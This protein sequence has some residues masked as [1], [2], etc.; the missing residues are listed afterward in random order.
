M[1]NR[2]L[3]WRHNARIRSFNSRGTGIIDTGA[4]AICMDRRIARRLGLTSI[5]RKP[6]EMADGASTEA[7][8]YMVQMSIPDLDYSEWTK[9]F[10]IDMK[11]PTSR[12]LLGRSFLRRY[13]L[14]YDGPR[15]IFH[16]QLAGP[17]NYEEHDG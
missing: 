10:G 11:F 5:D 17:T 14:T 4:S 8:A 2:T 1:G 6:M 12:I 9:V 13:H 7:V 16:Y 3:Y 15:E